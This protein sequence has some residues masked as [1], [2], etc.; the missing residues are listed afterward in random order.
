MT[1]KEFLNVNDVAVHYSMS[2]A[3][4][5]RAVKQCTIPQPIKITPKTTR[6]RLTDLAEWDELHFRSI[7]LSPV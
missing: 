7:S 2:K 6:W 5:W 3:S 4:V 1:N